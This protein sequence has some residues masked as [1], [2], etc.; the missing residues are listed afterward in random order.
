MIQNGSKWSKIVPI[1]KKWLKMIEM[2]KNGQNRQKWSKLTKMVKIAKM[3]NIAKNDQNGL[4]WSK[5]VPNDP[6]W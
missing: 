3:V 4:K 6:K 5:M 1:D 2:V